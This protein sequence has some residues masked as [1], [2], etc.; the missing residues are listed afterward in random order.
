MRL[1]LKAV[2]LLIPL[3]AACAGNPPRGLGGELPPP[4]SQRAVQ[5]DPDRHLGAEVRWGGE[6]L[7]VR[8]GERFTDVE[9]YGRPLFDN[10]EPRPEGGEGVRFIARVPGFLDPA[11]HAPGKR[12]TVRGRLAAALERKVG[13]YPYRYPLVEVS[14]HHLWPAYKEPPEPAWFRDPYYDPWWPWHPWGA[15]PYRRWP[16]GW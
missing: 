14:V 10:A 9:L 7:G 1:R 4:L 5:A 13:E 11:E 6:I 2:L 12:L 8:N 16:Y 3:L 15:W